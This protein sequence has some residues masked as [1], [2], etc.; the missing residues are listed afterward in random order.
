MKIYAA[1]GNQ[2]KKVELSQLFYPHTIVIPKAEGIDFDPVENGNTFVENTIIK[3]KAL[4]D[5]VKQPVL[6]DDS[7]ICID[8]LDG[9]PGIYSA[10]YIGNNSYS[11]KKISDSE[12]NILLLEEAYTMAK[13]K[14]I[15]ENTPLSCRFV[16]AMVL[17]LGKDRYYIAQET[18]EGELVKNIESAKGSGGFGYDP[19]V[20]LPEYGK[21]IAELSPEEKNTISHR[22]K[23]AKILHSIIEKKF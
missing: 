2:H 20:Y 9:K 21:T 3:A 8:I 1:T 11:E 22:G 19:I 14:G 4:F 15:S 6:A 16:C 5:I 18:I 13:E 7:G 12:R 17:Y 23:A 10:R